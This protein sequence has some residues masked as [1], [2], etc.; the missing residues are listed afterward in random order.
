MQVLD[1]G[2][3]VHAL[4]TAVLDRPR[5]VA[6]AVNGDVIPRSAWATTILTD[7]DHIVVVTGRPGG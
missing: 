6:V 4:A 1:D 7:D 2:T 3:T 5:G